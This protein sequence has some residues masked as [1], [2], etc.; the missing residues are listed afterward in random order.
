MVCADREGLAVHGCDMR[1]LPRGHRVLRYFEAT[2][3]I[4][5]LDWIGN[6]MS[7]VDPLLLPNAAFVLEANP[8]GLRKK[9]LRGDARV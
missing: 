7:R 1:L 8:K 4:P 3:S 9:I 2:N 6:A 5:I